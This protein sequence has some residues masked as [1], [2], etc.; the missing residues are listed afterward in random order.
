MTPN[1]SGSAALDWIRR[2]LGRL[3]REDR[4]PIVGSAVVDFDR[5]GLILLPSA[6]TKL[7]YLAG[8]WRWVE[9]LAA[10]DYAGAIVS[11]HWPRET[12]WTPEG[13]KKQITTFFGGD[14]PWSVVVPN[15]RL[16]GVLNDLAQFEPLDREGV[17]WF[18]AHIPLTT[19]PSNPKD[20][21]LP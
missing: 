8:F 16:I 1:F 4:G 13:L 5:D 14:R 12:R 18:M 7:D 19:E 20:D 17:G 11:L 3:R 9:L 2:L 21:A 10:D 15:E 6:D